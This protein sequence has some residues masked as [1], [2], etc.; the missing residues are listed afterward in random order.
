MALAKILRREKTN[1][2]TR[3]TTT[4]YATTVYVPVYGKTSFKIG[5]RGAPGNP[6]TGGNYVS[7]NPPSGGNTSY[8]PP[9][10]GDYAGTNPPSYGN[11]AGTNPPS[12]GNYAGTNPSIPGNSSGSNP[13]TAYWFGP[14]NASYSTFNSPLSPVPGPYS[15]GNYTTN[16]SSN[17]EYQYDSGGNGLS[18]GPNVPSPSSSYSSDPTGS[19]Y[20]T[21]SYALAYFVPGNPT[22]NPST[23]GNAY[24]N[25]P[26]SG[27]D[28]YNPGDPGNAYYNPTSPGNSYTN[29]TIPG[30]AN[31][32]PTTPGNPGSNYSLLGVTFP[33][34]GSDSPGTLVSPIPVTL[35]YTPGGTTITVLAGGYIDITNT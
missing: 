35:S 34:G 12:Y 26:S 13:G 16:F 30:N 3:G 21:S 20:F 23:P 14:T 18:S 32:N 33:G 9:S 6:S 22:Y 17:S 2:K 29:P 28:Y 15:Y 24:Y 27:F 25:P 31:Y 5:G 7:T 19:F 11:Y 1:P 4:F 10:G 8:N